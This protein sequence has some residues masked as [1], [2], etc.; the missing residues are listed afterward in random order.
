V[1]IPALKNKGA[2]IGSYAVVVYKNGEKDF[3]F[4]PFEDLEKVR[5]L[6]KRADAG[7]WSDHTEEMHKKTPLRR[8]FKR[9]PVSVEDQNMTLALALDNRAFMGKSQAQIMDPTNAPDDIP[10]AETVP[11]ETASSKLKKARA[12]ESTPAPEPE[13]VDENRVWCEAAKQNIRRETVTV[14]NCNGCAIGP[15]CPD[16]PSV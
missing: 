7:A 6:S 10:E 9:V 8:L 12:A 5:K 15:S 16:F 2:I 11:P 14:E 1:H 3:E 13:K 4:M